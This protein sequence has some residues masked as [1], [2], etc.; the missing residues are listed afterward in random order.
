[1]TKRRSIGE[2]LNRAKSP[3]VKQE[4]ARDWAADWAREQKLLIGKLEKA[5]KTDD[6]DQ[7]CIVTGQLK[8]VT[9]K[10]FN[11]LPNVIDKVAGVGNE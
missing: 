6:Y 5:V 11:A 8:A 7:M 1:M 9:E 3:E 4:V 2:R 10:R